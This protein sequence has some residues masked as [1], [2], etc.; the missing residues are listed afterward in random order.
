[1]FH[2]SR[3]SRDAADADHSYVSTSFI[4][5]VRPYTQLV[6]EDKYLEYILLAVLIMIR[7][8]H[9]NHAQFYHVAAVGND[10]LSGNTL[11]C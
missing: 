4:F 6:P 2:P 8:D 9:T 3:F 1:M 5:L 7:F 10:P 11:G